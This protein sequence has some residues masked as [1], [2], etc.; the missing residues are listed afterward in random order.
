[1]KQ[2]SVLFIGEGQWTPLEV[3][4]WVSA[5]IVTITLGVLF[6]TGAVGSWVVV[7]PG[8]MGVIVAAWRY[9]VEMKR[10]KQTPRDQSE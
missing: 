3:A 2:K 7:V 6:V 9:R 1:M 4:I 5:L 10:K 8:A